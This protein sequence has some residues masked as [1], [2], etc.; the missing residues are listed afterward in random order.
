MDDRTLN[1]TWEA[2]L[3]AVIVLVAAVLR[4]ADI[5]SMPLSPQET[6]SAL[7]AWN[8]YHGAATDM[9]DGSLLTYGT[10][11]I[12][13][14]FGVSDASA[15]VLPAVSGVVL[16]L[17]P[18][19]LRRQIGALSSLACGLFLAASPTLVLY[20]R[21]VDSV[22]VVAC[23]SLA[24]LAF[25]LKLDE[26]RRIE[27]AYAAAVA[28]GALVTAGPAAFTALV[29]LACF[30]LAR[31]WH[32]G[33]AEE[34]MS[35]TM[36]LSQIGNRLGQNPGDLRE[37]ELVGA[38]RIRR[39]VSAGAVTVL[40]L[41]TGLL[42]N[43]HGIQEG[44]VDAAGAWAGALA[45]AGSTG[46][47][48]SLP[49]LLITYDPVLTL[50]GLAG[51]IMVASTRHRTSGG[52]LWWLA[53][54]SILSWAASGQSPEMTVLPVVSVAV[55]GG[56]QAGALLSGLREQQ[57]RR[58]LLALASV[59]VP[60]LWLVVFALGHLS[61]PNPVVPSIFGALPVTCL[62]LAVCVFGLK[63]G[64][65]RMLGT[66][67]LIGVGVLIVLSVHTSSI[68]QRGEVEPPGVVV[69][70]GDVRAL[71]RDVKEARDAMAA[72]GQ[73]GPIRVD[74]SL[75]YPLAWYLR[76][77]PVVFESH[78]DSQDC[79]FIAR[80]DSPAPVWHHVT[81]RYMLLRTGGPR[82]EGFGQRWLWYFYREK[83]DGSVSVNVDLH[84]RT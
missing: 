12:F 54:I 84:V 21:Q 71:V 11:L 7:A 62:V 47:L 41:A 50:L 40:I 79:M 44:V 74:K 20:S 31:M 66:I 51:V 25:V 59:A 27:W 13:F 1:I 34:E 14:L 24:V 48:A 6:A 46:S 26:T 38:S 28:G 43:L 65:G 82:A 4:F 70:V 64:W 83:T 45:G 56:I 60:L 15:R 72:T 81:Q 23:L 18:A 9:P 3:W 8:V 67:G 76:D 16:T 52:L 39:S 58:D 55:L 63:V 61:R 73:E 36:S 68:L 75:E 10:A 19:L 80:A 78:P 42:L 5:G 53:A 22:M 69:T 57:T 32:R 49:L 77:V 35:G 2:I 29:G 30:A 17:L 33:A 37:A